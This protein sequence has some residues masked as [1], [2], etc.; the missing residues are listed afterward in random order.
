MLLLARILAS[1]ILLLIPATLMGGTLPLLTSYLVRKEGKFGKNFSMLYGLNTF[2]AVAGV[3]LAGFITIGFWGE[4]ATINIGVL[5]NLAVG[6]AGYLLYRKT[7][8]QPLMEKAKNWKHLQVI[9]KYP[10]I[11]T[12]YVPSY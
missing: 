10:H 7:G 6:I 1:F 5:L 12:G 11:V 8:I 2:G 4:Q 9:Y 3:L